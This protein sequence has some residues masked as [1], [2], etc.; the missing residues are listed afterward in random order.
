MI[1][2]GQLGFSKNKTRFRPAI[3]L[4]RLGSGL[5]KPDPWPYA[6][7]DFLGKKEQDEVKEF[8]KAN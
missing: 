6:Y 2:A 5:A 7:C 4:G 8:Q 1:R 3:L